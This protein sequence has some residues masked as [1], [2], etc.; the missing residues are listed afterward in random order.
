MTDEHF[1]PGSNGSAPG[2][3]ADDV[4]D[5]STVSVLI[6]EDDPL[7]QRTIARLVRYAGAR[8]H[9]MRRAAEYEGL[10]GRFDLGVFDIDLPDGNGIALARRALAEGRIGQVI[11]FSGSSREE[12]HEQARALG[13]F[14]SKRAGFATLIDRVKEVAVRKAVRATPGRAP[15]SGIFRK[16]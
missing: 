15:A 16:E 2:V 1:G 3:A 9:T 11:F 5:S 14:I 7:V 4:Q 13:I 12:T 10:A 8:I 6:V